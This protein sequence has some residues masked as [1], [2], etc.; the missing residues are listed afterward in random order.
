M[1][2]IVL[3]SWGTIALA[4]FLAELT[5]KDA[6]LI[7]TAS[8]RMR[9]GVVFAAGATAFVLTSALFV[10]AGAVLISFVPVVLVRGAGGVVMLAYGVWELSGAVGARGAEGGGKTAG[11]G[12][13]WRAFLALVGGLAL[14]DVAGDAT[15]IL[16]IVFVAHY[17]SPLLVFLGAV[18]GLVCATAVETALGSRLGHLLTPARV[19]YGSAAVFLVLGSAILLSALQGHLH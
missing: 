6:F 7:L 14:L 13:A 19:K 3:A 8:T 5:D 15:E 1:P 11:S 2:Y 9:P 10:S 4:L 16:T 17:S 12:S 18:T